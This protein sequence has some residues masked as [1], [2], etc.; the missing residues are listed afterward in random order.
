MSLTLAE[1]KAAMSTYTAGF[2][3]D[4]VPTGR[5]RELLG[6]AGAIERM[7]ATVSAL[8]AARLARGAVD[9]DRPGGA[10]R[11]GSAKAAALS[12]AKATG[13]SLGEARRAIEAGQAMADQ[14]EVSSAARAGELSRQQ[15]YLVSGAA[16]A[17]PGATAGLLAT[18]RDGSLGELAT[19]AARARAAASDLD[20]RRANV[21]AA[22]SLREWTDPYGTWQLH[23]RGLPED[24]ARVMAALGPLAERAFEMAREEGRREAPE[25]Y[26]FDALVE[27]ASG[28]GGGASGYEVMV[29]VDHSA[30]LRGYVID[31]ETCEIPGFG[32]VSPQVV[33]DIMECG[34]PFYKSILTKGK[35][36]VGVAH[37]GRRPNAHQ[38]SALD[39]L[40]PTCAVEGCGVRSRHCQTDHRTDWAQSHVTV[41]ELLD[42]LCKMHHDLKTYQGWGLVEGKGKR[43]FVP[44]ED[45]R[46]PRHGASAAPPGPPPAPPAPP[47]GPAQP[48]PR[49]GPAPSPL[50]PTRA[51]SQ[52]GPPGRQP[53]LP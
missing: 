25:A 26:A 23:A 43:A 1:L 37:L 47:P 18:A 20:Q 7:A 11:A 13:T 52:P 16:E 14:P 9:R 22:R 39:W 53:R 19:E 50:T 46:H 34:D 24:G 38:R 27:L 36:V 3:A 4:L 51:A 21:R 45:P 41:F 49:P 2:D 44:P 48:A 5:L 35:D 40:Y 29:R 28:P 17:N 31:G 30:L 33:A 6:D 15:A 12:L 32:P 42:R 10:G 8:V